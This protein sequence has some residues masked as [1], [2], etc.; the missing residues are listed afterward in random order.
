MDTMSQQDTLFLLDL[1]NEEAHEEACEGPTHPLGINGHDHNAPAAWML[2]PLCGHDILMCDAWVASADALV[3]SGKYDTWEFECV[4]CGEVTE[5]PD[6][7]RI[8]IK[9]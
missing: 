4:R 8:R 3:T 9:D 5:D 2:V 6:L 1:E 7:V